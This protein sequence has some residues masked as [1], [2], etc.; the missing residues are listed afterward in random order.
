MNKEKIKTLLIEP[1]ESPKLAYI[2]PSMSV[3][4][5]AVNADN[6]EHG[7]VE[8][9][10]LENN[11]YAVFNK[12]RFLAD[13]EPNR[14]IG[15]DIISGN[16]YVIATDDIGFPVSLTDFQVSKYT[17]RFLYPEDFEDIDV[18]EA[19]LNTMFSRFLKDED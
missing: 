6:I 7:G 1:K 19:N 17:L 12:D 10:K 16:I 18:A 11:V 5:K 4:R 8:A 3:L 2:K 15:D 14:Y 9:K 13:L